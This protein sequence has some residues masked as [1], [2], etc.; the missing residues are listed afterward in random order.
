M[1]RRVPAAARM[2]LVMIRMMT[3]ILWMVTAVTTAAL[4]LVVILPPLGPIL[5]VPIAKL[6]WE[7][8]ASLIPGL[9]RG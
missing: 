3:P 6:P 5:Q 8:V 9:E 7:M 2:A 1:G 4:M